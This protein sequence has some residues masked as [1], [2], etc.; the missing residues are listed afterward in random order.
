[1]MAILVQNGL[2]KVVTGKKSREYSIAGGI[3]G[4]DLICLVEKVRNS[5]CN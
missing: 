1:M 4:E 3:D 2:K 5:L